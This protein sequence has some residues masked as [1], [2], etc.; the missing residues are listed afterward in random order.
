MLGFK[1]QL[2]L[3]RLIELDG[4]ARHDEEV[5][6]LDLDDGALGEQVEPR[7]LDHQLRHFAMDALDWKTL[8]CQVKKVCA[9]MTKVLT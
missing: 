9:R 1:L 4:G 3:F 5:D 6:A 2:F 7:H 8:K